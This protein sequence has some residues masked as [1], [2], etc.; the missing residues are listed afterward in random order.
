MRRALV[1]LGLGVCLASAGLPATG[2]PAARRIAFLVDS[3]YPR[4]HA[5]VIGTRFLEGYRLG[6]RTIASPLTVASVFAEAPRPN[7]QTRALA[8]RYG[9]RVASSVTDALLDG[10]RLAVDGVLIATREDL[11]ERGMLPSPTPRLGTV[12]QVL[13]IFDQSGRRVPVF[14]D[15]MLAANWEDSQA[16]VAES[17]RREIPL[18]GGSVLP[19]LPLDR[20]VRAGR[21]VVAVAIA[22]TPFRAFGIHAAE[23]LQGYLEQRDTRESGV[24]SIREVGTGYWTLPEREEWGGRLADAL[25]ASAQTRRSRAPAVP[26]GLG[27]ETTVFLIRY[28][29]G[30]RAVLAFIPRLFDDR[31]FL[32]GA[33]YADGSTATG[34]VV[35]QADPFDH[36]GYL[37]HALVALYTTGRPPTAAERT[38]LSTGIVLAGQEARAT[39][40]AVAWPGLA[41]TYQVPHRSP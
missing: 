12:R 19:F 22:S 4:S 1:V 33:R 5:D 28:V 40:R 20:P 21:V 30:T 34:G 2:A 35:L 17:A 36:F 31:E 41:V 10:S 8:A 25:L 27:P 3:W 26:A 14:I 24:A 9:F 6:S 11:P 38:L 37:V 16:I 18:M 23:L 32:L 15:K 13:R 39:G 7:D 29:D